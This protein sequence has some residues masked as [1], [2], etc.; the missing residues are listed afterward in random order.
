MLT[1]LESLYFYLTNSLRYRNYIFWSSRLFNLFF[2]FWNTCFLFYKI[3][4]LLQKNLIPILIIDLSLKLT[5]LYMSLFYSVQ[6]HESFMKHGSYSSL[7]DLS[8]ITAFRELRLFIIRWCTLNVWI[9][10]ILCENFI[11]WIDAATT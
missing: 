4:F 8:V 5:L 6:L 1:L 9:I 10:L 11:M 2:S 3:F 7:N